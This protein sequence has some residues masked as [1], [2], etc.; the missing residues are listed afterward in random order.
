[1]K[2][3]LAL[4]LTLFLFAPTAYGAN[5]FGD[6]FDYD[7]GA[8]NFFDYGDGQNFWNDGEVAIQVADMADITTRQVYTTLVSV[9][10]ITENP[11]DEAALEAY[12]ESLAIN[13]E[14]A[15]YDWSGLSVATYDVSAANLTQSIPATLISATHALASNHNGPGLGDTCYWRTPAGQM[16]S[17]TVAA[18]EVIAGS[19]GELRLIRFATN[20]GATLKRYPICTDASL[21]SYVD[22]GGYLWLLYQ[23]QRIR[24]R[25]ATSASSTAVFH[26]DSVWHNDVTT[27]SGRPAMVAL[28]NNALIVTGTLWGRSYNNRTSSVLSTLQSKLADHSE[29][30]A[31]YA[32]PLPSET[33]EPGDV[34]FV[35]YSLFKGH[36][37]GKGK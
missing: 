11:L 13:P 35:G 7:G 18:G 27:G 36:V 3:R 10:G 30:L 6:F 5:F 4:L 21:A 1:M 8:K 34:E 14:V 23:D 9:A 29:T 24:L 31:T 22:A 20:P 12:I 16:V 32:L 2:S 37:F 15:A 26:A 25:V 19:G 28:T 33:E 17:A